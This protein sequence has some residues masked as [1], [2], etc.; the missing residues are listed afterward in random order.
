MNYNNAYLQPQ[1]AGLFKGVVVAILLLTL[2]GL[3]QR[4]FAQE[5]VL[6]KSSFVALPGNKIE[7]KLDFDSVPPVP[8]A[9]TIDSPPRLVLD[10]WG[11][12]NDLGSKSVDVKA[13]VVESLNFAQGNGRLRIVTN[14][15]GMTDY[16]TFTEGNSLFVV[17]GEKPNTSMAKTSSKAKPMSAKRNVLDAHND[18]TRV[19][20]IDFERVAG[21]VG[22]VV[23]TLSDDQAGL[24]IEEEG[25]N[26]AVNFSG[27][28]LS[29]SLQ[30]RVNVQDFATPV[31][32][33]DAM[34]SGRN[35]TVLI[36]P[37][38]E[39][40]DY[41]AYQ[42][43]NKLILDFKPLS[44]AEKDELSKNEFPYSGEKIDLNFQNV[45]VR[46]VLQILAEVAQLN[47]VVDD[48]VEGEITLRLKHVPWD[49]ALDI[50]MKTRGLDKRQVGNVLLV[51]PAEDIA[52]RERVELESQKQVEELSPLK[53][54]FIQVD[55]RKASE[56][57]SRIYEAKLVSERGFIVA[58]DQTNVLMVRE[59]TTQ[60]EE[61]R[62]TLRRFD[63]EVAQIMVE[64]RLV[65]A[66][67][68]FTRNL[69]IKWGFGLTKGGFVTDGGSGVS[70]Y[71]TAGI[72]TI[73]DG[74]GV[75]LGVAP[76]S[77]IRLGYATNNFLISTELSALQSEGKAEIVSQP[78][79]IT[80]NG[81]AARIQSGQ[82]IPY[83]TVED[84]EVKIEFKDVVLSLDVTPQLNPGDRITLDI[85]INQDSLGEVLPNGEISIINNELETS[86]VV[87]DGDTVVLGGVY[88]NEV[89]DAIAKTPFFGDLPGIGALFR[90]SEVS[91]SKVEL[92]IFIT[93]KLIRE[94]LSAK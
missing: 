61:I 81:K 73:S 72:G 44:R 11:V 75:D 74:L 36:K 63:T 22:R 12:K 30:Q 82:E 28:T 25:N 14:L 13:G 53:T 5:V 85:K 39:P 34:A 35:T 49:Q 3:S 51:A 38:A 31:M 26:V 94:S 47:L 46:S 17:F 56:M 2:L 48:A 70:P 55:Y 43:G 4:V 33:V 45:S 41:M 92:L 9:Y 58:D 86:V 16:R 57:R 76:T 15:H 59:T 93:P 40:Y 52:E 64:A 84:G 65:T 8:K 78:K 23:I 42:T 19:Q 29:A 62:R 87:K 88:R 90:K 60:L 89:A 77:A 21:G 68:D 18:K 6:Q 27:A 32:Y 66:S 24:N 69:G 7:V 67:T 80:T 71:S 79:I 1:G 37:G 91:T 83:Q 54:D 50:V 10:F 20:G